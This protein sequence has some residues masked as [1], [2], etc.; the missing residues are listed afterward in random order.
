MKRYLV[1]GGAGFIGSHLVDA[2]LARGDAVRVLDDLSTGNLA[3]LTDRAEFIEGDIGNRSLVEDCLI[4]VDGCFHLAAISSIHGSPEMLQRAHQVNL[5]GSTT[6]FDAIATLAS[7]GDTIPIVYASSAAVYGDAQAMPISEQ[8]S[9]KPIS[10]YGADKVAVEEYARDC[11]ERSGVPSTGFRFFN[12]YGPRQDPESPYSGVIS[13]FL[14]RLLADEAVEIFGDGEQVRDFV[15][16]DDAVRFLLAAMG[17]TSAGSEVFNVCTGRGTT[18]DHLYRILSELAEAHAAVNYRP[19]RSGDIRQSIGDP[20]A[21]ERRYTMLA[22]TELRE[23]LRQTRCYQAP[24]HNGPE[25]EPKS[26]KSE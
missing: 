14:D 9:A 23:G 25:A 21:A 18:I 19:A 1:T 13:I 16:V 12:V 2:L 24:S 10:A 3:N 17:D 11:W 20:A 6:I 7:N 4:D 8:T 26:A 15:Y 22:R 5:V